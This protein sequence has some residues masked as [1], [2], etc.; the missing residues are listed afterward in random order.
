VP[1]ANIIEGRYN[2]AEPQL[3]GKMF[4]FTKVSRLMFSKEP[5]NENQYGIYGSS[6]TI[7]TI[8]RSLEKIDFD[9]LLAPA[10]R[11]KAD[12]SQLTT[13]QGLDS[14]PYCPIR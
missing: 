14:E 10:P 7:M 11:R 9:V 12:G 6:M 1:F 3:V 5:S 4:D 8:G 2:T 13:F